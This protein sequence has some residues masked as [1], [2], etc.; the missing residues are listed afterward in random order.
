MQCSNWDI[1]SFI[2]GLSA[3]VFNSKMFGHWE[4][5]NSIHAT[6]QLSNSIIITGGAL[7][8]MGIAKIASFMSS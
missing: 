4:M 5:I 3:L 2:L 7:I 1:K 8:I 6:T